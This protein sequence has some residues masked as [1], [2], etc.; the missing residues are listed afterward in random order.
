MVGNAIA[1][2]GT[3]CQKL[4]FCLDCFLSKISFTFCI[5]EL[6]HAYYLEDN[7]SDISG[8]DSL[9]LGYAALACVAE[10]IA[11]DFIQIPR[12]P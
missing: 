9:M 3:A 4:N 1:Y 10:Q 2:P 12:T 6:S 8:L 5:F 7:Q 11:K